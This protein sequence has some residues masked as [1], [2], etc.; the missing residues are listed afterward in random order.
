MF[1]PSSKDFQSFALPYKLSDRNYWCL[2][3][4]SNQQPIDYKSIALPI[5]LR[6]HNGDPTGTRTR[7]TSVKGTCLNRLTIGPWRE[8]TVLTRLT[9]IH[10]QLPY[11]WATFPIIMVENKRLEL[12]TPAVQ[13]QCSTN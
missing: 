10:S 1:E 12:S 11:L 2:L 13:V 3:P 4:E 8:R 6:R 5:E 7:D 9:L